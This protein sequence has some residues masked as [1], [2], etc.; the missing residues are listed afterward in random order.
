MLFP[1]HPPPHN[2]KLS[3]QHDADRLRVRDVFLLQNA[4]RQRVFIVRLENGERLLHNDCA[5][6]EF[7]VHKVHCATRNFHAIGKRLLLRL[8]TWKRGQLRWMDIEN[9]LRELLHEPG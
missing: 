5:V 2:L 8:E 6:I 9:S 1:H 7:F 4:C 3:R